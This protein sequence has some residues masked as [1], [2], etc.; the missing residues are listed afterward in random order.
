MEAKV[1]QVLCGSTAILFL[2]GFL[3][4]A[5]VFQIPW[6]GVAALGAF[7][8]I[9]L[10]LFLLAR[11]AGKV[12]PDAAY[13]SFLLLSVPMW[14]S[15]GGSTGPVPLTYIMN[16]V[17]INSFFRSWR[18][19]TYMALAVLF[20]TGLSIAE[21]IYPDKVS[22]LP[23]SLPQ[24]LQSSLGQGLIFL[25]SFLAIRLV[26]RSYDEEREKVRIAN[27]EL[28]KRNRELQEMA[29]KDRMTGLYNHQHCLEVL[30]QECLR[31]KRHDWP[32]SLIMMDIDHFK[33]INDTYGHLAGDAVLVK[34]AEILRRCT[35]NVDFLGRYGG[36][37]FLI[38]LP[39]TPLMGAV[40]VAERIRREFHRHQFSENGLKVSV[41]LGVAEYQ[42]E[43]PEKFLDRADR[44]LYRAKQ[45]GRD[46]TCW[47]LA[48]SG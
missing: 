4:L 47:V 20:G 40:D 33:A 26:F 18:L 22:Q 5:V 43:D 13:L 29:L 31:S 11:L 34:T 9:T 32:L 41:S 8:V 46:R 12:Y 19:N 16:M 25:F 39:Q 44:E 23:G 27:I 48:K 7:G 15:F 37:E 42:G 10:L 36:E 14:F 30:T 38:L 28:E 45:E 24:I 6:W 35:R 1:F 3:P 21:K 2:I 17:L